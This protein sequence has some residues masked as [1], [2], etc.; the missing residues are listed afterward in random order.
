MTSQ[1]VTTP[2]RRRNDLPPDPPA[3]PVRV[4]IV[5]DDE[6]FSVWLASIARRLGLTVTTAANG[7]EALRKLAAEHFDL[8]ISDFEMP[9]KDG[10]ALIAE[11]RANSEMSGLYAVMLTAHDELSVKVT[12]LTLG[13]DD[14]LAKGCTE[15]EVVAKVAA[16][17]RILA[18][19]RALDADAR[20]WRDIANHDELTR[21]AT[22]RYFF[23][24]AE[25]H[26]AQ[27]DNIA[28][29]LFDVNDFKYINDN[30]G[31]LM[32]DR[33]LKDMGGLFLRRTRSDDVI[34]RYGGDEFVLLVL[35]LTVDETRAV[36]ERLAAELSSLQWHE[37]DATLQVGV[38]IGMGCSSLMPAG[39]T[40][41][42]LL[43]VADQELYANK[44]L[45][46][47]PTTTPPEVYEYPVA[48][49]STVPVTAAHRAGTTSAAYGSS[50]KESFRDG[51]SRG[52]R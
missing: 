50:P 9:R 51:S 35:N 34:A 38:T 31:H 32:G 22:R 6:N 17:R 28:V 41:Q 19:Q 15:V 39:A 25:R 36:A 29:V 40:I 48:A 7:V 23:E 30:Y 45:K 37:R 43:E 14:F 4:L 13:Y 3:E 44:W 42:Q 20:E 18:R 10:L 5:E 11:V 12:A 52:R 26:I 46:K 2:Q 49:A 21:V 16:A 24:Q 33:V 8:L 27:K 47:H 1:R